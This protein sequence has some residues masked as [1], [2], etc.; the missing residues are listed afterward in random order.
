[1]L[2]G[3]EKTGIQMPS[4]FDTVAT[5][6]INTAHGLDDKLRSIYDTQ[7]G[8]HHGAMDVDEA[9]NAVQGSGGGVIDSE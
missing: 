3:A 9:R 1:M 2:P 7:G 6:G 4:D 8:V 5:G